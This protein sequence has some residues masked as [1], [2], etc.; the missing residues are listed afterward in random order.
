MAK[1][2]KPTCPS[3]GS[4]DVAMPGFCSFVYRRGRWV[5]D[6]YSCETAESE[7]LNCVCGAQLEHTGSPD[8]FDY[9]VVTQNEQTQRLHGIYK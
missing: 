9:V 6:I 4:T 8:E 7:F 1:L 2:K 5:V 3:C